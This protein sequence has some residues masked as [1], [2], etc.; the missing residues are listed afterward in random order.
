MLRR[1]EL[2][3]GLTMLVAGLLVIAVGAVFP[4]SD[5]LVAIGW[6]LFLPVLVSLCGTVF[7]CVS[8][9]RTR[10]SARPSA[11]VYRIVGFGAMAGLGL[12]FAYGAAGI[13]SQVPDSL[14]GLNGPYVPGAANALSAFLLGGFGLVI[15]LALGAAAAVAWWFVSG[16]HMAPERVGEPIA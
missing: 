2:I 6:L 4:A 3:I 9:A 10:A 7:V 5:R 16:R 8:L 14:A 13:L 1:H 12:A 15:G 11:V